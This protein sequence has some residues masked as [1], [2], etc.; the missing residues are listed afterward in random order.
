MLFDETALDVELVSFSMLVG[1]CYLSRF[2][3]GDDGG[4][5]PEQRERSHFARDGGRG[6]GSGEQRLCWRNDFDFHGVQRL[7]FSNS[8]PLAMASS[9]VPTRL[10]AAS[11]Y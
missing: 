7:C 8:S 6:D 2:Q 5:I 3:D 1:Q 4:V 9:M 11:G 10:N